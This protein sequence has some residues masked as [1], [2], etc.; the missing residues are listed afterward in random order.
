MHEDHIEKRLSS[1][2]ESH[3]KR[4]QCAYTVNGRRDAINYINSLFLFFFPPLFIHKHNPNHLLPVLEVIAF[5]FFFS[6]LLFFFQINC[7]TKLTRVSCLLY[8]ALYTTLKL[9]SVNSALVSQTIDF[10][11]VFGGKI[12][13]ICDY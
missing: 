3:L 8:M 2:Q 10:T 13:S 11:S 12:E 5:F 1:L 4:L 9:K 6:F 7:A